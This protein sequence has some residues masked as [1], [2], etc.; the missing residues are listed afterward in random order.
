MLLYRDIYSDSL[1]VDCC[2]YF[3][4]TWGLIQKT[5]SLYLY[6][7]VETCSMFPVIVPVDQVLGSGL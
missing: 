5:E 1:L 7:Q 4:C 2:S 3:L 6:L